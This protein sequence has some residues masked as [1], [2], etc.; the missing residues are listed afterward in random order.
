MRGSAMCG[1]RVEDSLLAE[2]QR[3]AN[4]MAQL[5][6]VPVVVVLRVEGPQAEV[7]VS[8]ETEGNPYHRGDRAAF[9]GSRLF[10]E[11]VVK[12]RAPL[13]IPDAYR[14]VDWQDKY[15]V[16]HG[17]R[18]YLGYPLFFPDGSIFGTLCV[19]DREEHHHSDLVKGVVEGLKSLI[20][21][22]L[23]LMVKNAELARRVAE[24]RQLRG[25]IPIC[26]HCKRVRDDSG[27]WEAVETYVGS[28]AN[29]EFS[30]GVCPDCLAEHYP[31]RER[32]K[33]A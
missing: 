18:S 20:E 16:R 3:V 15:A 31:A 19:L 32:V 21:S 17:L 6:G 30:H 22:H 2:W 12:N 23:A 10:C 29:V 14:V 8:S 9:E 4:L 25:I 7:L 33:G 11:Y 24:V 27:Y 5:A 1:L 28:L 13:E 26:A